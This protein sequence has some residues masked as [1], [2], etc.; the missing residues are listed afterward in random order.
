MGD[1]LKRVVSRAISD[2]A[3]RRQLQTNPKGALE[4][5]DLSAAETAALTSADPTKLAG[6]GIDQRMSR[7]FAAPFESAGMPSRFETEYVGGAR[8]VVDAG[9]GG[10]TVESVDPT[11][12]GGGGLESLDAGTTAGG[13]PRIS[14]FGD[15]TAQGDELERL[16]GDPSAGTGVWSTDDPYGTAQ[17]DRIDGA[18]GGQDLEAN[19]NLDDAPQGETGAGTPDQV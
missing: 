12:A 11:A 3:F 19:A 2:A 1:A 9:S 13:M 4:E 6:L 14:D 7:M 18:T 15:G 10:P 17:L 8:A 16:V 5:F